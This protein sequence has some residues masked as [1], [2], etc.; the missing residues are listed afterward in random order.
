MHARSWHCAAG[1]KTSLAT[2]NRYSPPAAGEFELSIFGPGVG[3]SVV[4]HVGD[5]Q[6]M[7]VDSCLDPFS[8]K[9][10]A[11]N[12]LDQLPT[13]DGRRR[14]ISLVL[15]HW[16]DDHT[17][18][19]AQILRAAPDAGF[20]CSVAFKAQELQRALEVQRVGRIAR[21]GLEELSDVFEV[22]KERGQR[23][24]LAAADRQLA[25]GSQATMRA[26]SPSDETI[27]RAF[28]HLQ[29]FTVVPGQP[30]TRLPRHTQND[31]S[32]ALWIEFAGVRALLG[33]DLETPGW[34][35]MVA[36]QL[37]PTGAN[38]FKVPH[39]GSDDADLVDVWTK[40]LGPNPCALLTPYAASRKPRPAPEDVL[41]L[42]SRT[43]H[44]HV[45]SAASAKKPH[46]FS[47]TVSRKIREHGARLRE[48]ERKMGHVRVRAR[49]GRSI[50]VCHFDAA[51]AVP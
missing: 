19:A 26:L 3:E 20:I 13:I 38:I 23:P 7:I 8:G 17:K 22:L 45:S 50:E 42:R 40:M 44:V 30:R 16:H 21:S 48:V 14:I 2:N 12:Y 18:G 25:I 31:A 29:S 39:H 36:G 32:V 37:C 41:R 11:L 46:D 49:A 35:A 5:D 6:W 33:G 43:P 4:L 27:W 28:E 10:I 24:V 1:M 34:K 15:T 47:K 9:A 51:Y